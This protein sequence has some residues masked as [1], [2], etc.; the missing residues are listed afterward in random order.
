MHM[1]RHDDE[2]TDLESE[3]MPSRRHLLDD[4]SSGPFRIEQRQP[5]LARV[6]QEVRM[7]GM[8]VDP[9][10]LPVLIAHSK[11]CATAVSAVLSSQMPPIQ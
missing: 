6:G 8:V 2:R 7:T 1:L 4:P 9:P 10:L 11:Q 5:L 3:P